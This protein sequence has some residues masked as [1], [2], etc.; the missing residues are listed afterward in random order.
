MTATPATGSPRSVPSV[1]S[2]P[3]VYEVR[4]GTTTDAPAGAAP[5]MAAVRLIAQLPAPWTAELGDCE[6]PY[7]TLAFTGEGSARDLAAVLDGLLGAGALRGW[8]RA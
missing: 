5:E 8:A 1:P 7:A 4:I 6:G 3:S 2:V